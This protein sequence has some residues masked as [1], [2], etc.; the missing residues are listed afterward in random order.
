MVTKAREVYN[1]SFR[2]L[3]V[4]QHDKIWTKFISWAMK[5]DNITSA[6]RIIPR[7]LKVNPDFKETYAEYLIERNL[8]DKAAKIYADILEDDGYSSK[9]GKD[10]KDFY[11]ELINLI[12]EHPDKITCIKGEVIIR[13]ALKLYP[14]DAGKI[15]V[16]M[17]DYFIRLGEF[18]KAREL[19]EE[20]IESVDNA[21]DFGIIFSAYV[22]FSE[23]MITALA[24]D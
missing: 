14:E 16:K 6:L 9:A 20:A 10:K 24:N 1:W 21:K 8:F 2:N 4:T 18:E 17:N 5:L 12:T 19:L 7:Y 11:F 23:E 22:K 3:P 13:D 15:W